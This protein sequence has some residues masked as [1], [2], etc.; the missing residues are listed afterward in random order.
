MEIY[1]RWWGEGRV[2]GAF[3]VD[4]R[5]ADPRVSALKELGLPAVVIGHPSRPARSPPS[6]PT[7]PSPSAR[8]SN[9]WPRSATA[10]SPASPACPT[11][12]TPCSAT[13]PSPPP[14]RT[15]AST[16]TPS[17]TPTTPAR[18]APAPPAG[19]SA[20]QPAH[21]DRLRQR[22]HGRRRHVGRPRD[23]ARRARRPVHRGLGRLTPLPGRTPPADRAH[24]GHPGLRRARGPDAAVPDRRRGGGGSRGP[25]GPPPPPRQRGPTEEKT[26]QSR[27]TAKSNPY[28]ASYHP[29]VAHPRLSSWRVLRGGSTGARW[30]CRRW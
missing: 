27:R 18:R 11:S 26:R 8:P 3:L 30:G 5:F 24:P 15:S 4:L 7:R 21:G 23:A 14:A 20:P 1:R 9:T 16:G 2:D 6:G 25:G 29:A 13:R 12:S 19:S 10:A 28:R 22:H 17:C